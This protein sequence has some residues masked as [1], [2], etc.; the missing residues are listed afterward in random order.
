LIVNKK[1]V[2]RCGKNYARALLSTCDSE[3]LN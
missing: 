3:K 2:K 1:L